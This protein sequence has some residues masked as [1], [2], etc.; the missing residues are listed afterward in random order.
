MTVARIVC[1]TQALYFSVTGPWPL[2]D[3]QS[4]QDV[5]GEKTDHWLVYTV[6]LLITVIGIVLLLAVWR[7]QITSEI[8][9]LGLA[10]AAVLAS[11]DVIFVTRKTISPIYLG[12]AAV[13]LVFVFGWT[14]HAIRSA[15]INRKSANRENWN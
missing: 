9:L 4:F 15:L 1:W 2:I 6:A 12:D 11:I 8:A 5:T 7:R 14:L 3:I 13:E 10:S